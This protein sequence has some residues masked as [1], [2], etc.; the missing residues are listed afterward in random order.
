MRVKPGPQL[1]VLGT[2]VERFYRL[3][4]LPVA[5]PKTLKHYTFFNLMLK[6]NVTH[7]L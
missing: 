6:I 4:V 5:L 3:D 7:N 2:A 1:E